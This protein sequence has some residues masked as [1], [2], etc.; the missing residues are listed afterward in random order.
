MRRKA[1]TRASIVQAGLLALMLTACSHT[2]GG[3]ALTGDSSPSALP[4]SS[5]FSASSPDDLPPQASEVD[6]PPS[7]SASVESSPIQ[8]NS[9]E[10]GAEA[11]TET[12]A[13]AAVSSSET[14]P[15][16][17][18]E[19]VPPKKLPERDLDPKSPSLAGIRLGDSLASVSKQLGTARDEYDLPDESDMIHMKDYAGVTVGF[20]RDN[21]AV[22]IEL[23]EIGASSGIK[24]IGLGESG[25]A[26]A[27][28][29]GLTLAPEDL[30]LLLEV[31][32][33]LYKIDLDP[34]TGNTM[35]VKLIGQS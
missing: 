20:G 5:A 25:Q 4:E 6:F 10:T 35:S 13:E 22:Y 32:G 1:G 3:N 26:A 18:Q 23:T 14:E 31:E 8:G 21:R 28:A 2:T 17:A 9:A 33:G 19:A 12:D 27:D 11:D 7:P 34:S 30:L 24:G 16:P 15:K 29:L